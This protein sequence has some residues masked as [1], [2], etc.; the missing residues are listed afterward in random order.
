MQTDIVGFIFLDE[1][2]TPG[3][4]AEDRSD[5]VLGGDGGAVRGEF[6]GCRGMGVDGV[7]GADG[8]RV[9][10]GVGTCRGGMFHR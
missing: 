9:W 1:I 5:D 8:V 2:P 7:P 3:V 4:D 6:D 10:D